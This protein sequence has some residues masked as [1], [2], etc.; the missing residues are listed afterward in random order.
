MK[1]GIMTFLLILFMLLSSCSQLDLSTT[2]TTEPPIM[3]SPIVIREIV[4]TPTVAVEYVKPVELMPSQTPV[5]STDYPS[6]VIAA[7]AHL[8][9]RLGIP[10]K[11]ISVVEFNY[12]E[13]PDACLGVSKPGTMCAQMVTPGYTI[14]LSADNKKY[15]YHTD[16]DGKNMKIVK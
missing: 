1:N 13:W 6:A 9:A 3:E 5:D 12:I 16:M 11:V 4:L 15:E 14:I 2:A 10:E 7:M 8:S